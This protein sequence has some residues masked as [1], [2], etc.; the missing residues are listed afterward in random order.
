MWSSLLTAASYSSTVKHLPANI[1]V[2]AY[3]VDGDYRLDM[4][5]AVRS[6]GPNAVASDVRYL[7][8]LAEDGRSVRFYEPWT[9]A[10]RSHQLADG[11][12]TV[13]YSDGILAEN[14][15]LVCGNG[16]KGFVIDRIGHGIAAD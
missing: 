13:A 14:T 15:A 11:V 12:L 8:V 2:T 9:A 3:F 5:D 10:V 7:E 6:A 16:P 1:H 4:L